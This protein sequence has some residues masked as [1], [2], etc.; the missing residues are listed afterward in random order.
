ML[1]I[2]SGWVNKKVTC[3]LRSLAPLASSVSI[4]CGN[5]RNVATAS[6][7]CCAGLLRFRRG[8]QTP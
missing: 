3:Y 4:C 6:A 8:P 5:C 7:R 1:S 2:L